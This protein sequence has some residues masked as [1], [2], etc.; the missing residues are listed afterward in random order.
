MNGGHRP[1]G[2]RGGC[3]SGPDQRPEGRPD[4][5]LR[6]R[7]LRTPRGADSPRPVAVHRLLRGGRRVRRRALRMR[8]H[9]AARQRRRRGPHL[10]RRRDR[11]ARTAPGPPLPGGRQVHRARRHRRAAHRAP[12]RRRT[13]RGRGR[14]RLEPGIPTRGLRHRRHPPPG[15]AGARRR[16]KGPRGR[17]CPARGVRPPR[18]RATAAGD[19]PGDRGTGQGLRKLLPGHEDL[20]HQRYGRGLRSVRGRRGAAQQ[21]P[22]L[23]RPDRRPVPE[24]GRRL[25]RGLPTQGHP[26]LSGPGRRTRRRPGPPLPAG[27]ERRQH[28]APRAGRTARRRAVRRRSGRTADRGVGRGVKAELRRHPRLAGPRAAGRWWVLAFSGP[29]AGGFVRE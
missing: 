8:G 29:P 24:R 28:A 7:A 4:A 2:T 14:T 17:S 27:G 22:V 23:R 21:G 10:R 5:F 13:G 3:R 6:A 16:P 1:R 9:P 26:G 18:P 25:R 12:C 15:P 11:H 20:V 19:G